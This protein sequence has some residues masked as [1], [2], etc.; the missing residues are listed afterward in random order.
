MQNL[1]NKGRPIASELQKAPTEMSWVG[2]KR[3]KYRE[4]IDLTE[5]LSNSPVDLAISK[6]TGHS[7]MYSDLEKQADLKVAIALQAKL[8]ESDAY[9]R[10]P[11]ISCLPESPHR[12]LDLASL[13]DERSQDLARRLQAQFDAETNIAT[14][15]QNKAKNLHNPDKNGLLGDSYLRTEDL[16]AV[17]IYGDE[18]SSQICQTCGTKI[19]SQM[20]SLQSHVIRWIETVGMET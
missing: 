13:D 9:I 2:T 18:I 16:H 8:E 17:Q 7:M 19:L 14:P 11:G 12:P 15:N 20:F 10:H 3:S 4:L 5:P 6:T 1:A